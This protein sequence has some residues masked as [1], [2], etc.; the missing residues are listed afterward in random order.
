MTEGKAQINRRP[1]DWY[2]PGR[3]MVEF[4]NSPHQIRVLIGGR[5]SGKTTAVAVDAIF[6]HCYTYS[7]AR[8]YILR[9]TEKS[10]QDTTGETFGIVFGN[11][12]TVFLDTGLSLFKKI[13][14]GRQYR[15]PS[16]R[17]IELWNAWQ[18]AHPTATKQ[19]KL[20]WLE[21]V[22]DKY[23]SYLL[24]SGVPTSGHRQSRFRGFEASMIILVEADQFDREDVDLAMA[25][26]RWKG[27]EEEQCDEKGFLVD[28]RLILDTN[29]PSPRHWIARW[30]EE[31]KTYD[32]DGYIKFW[33][34]RTEENEHNLPPGYVRG[35]KRQ[36]QRNRAMYLRMLEGQYA[37]AFDGSPVLWAFREDHAHPDLD[38]PQGAYLVCG[39]DFGVTAHATIFSAYFEMGGC[40]YWWDLYEYYD[41]ERDTETQCRETLKIL[42][43]VFP[44]HNDRMFCAGLMHFCDVAGKQRK[45]SGRSSLQVLHSYGIYPSYQKFGVPESIATYNRLLEQKDGSGR[46]CYRIDSKNCP[47]LYAGSA[48]G[49]RYPAEGE[50]GHGG[51]LPGKGPQFGNYDHAVDAARYAKCNLLRLA[52]KGRDNRP[53]VGKLKRSLRVNRPRKWR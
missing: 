47:M 43:K 1:D 26:L 48:G 38:F 39:W 31:S 11:S 52:K 45:D 34:L 32:D 46:W 2:R 14:G 17:A 37:E 42:D 24:F 27:V 35:L 29:P 5:G 49:Y 40:E 18:Q 12:G 25:C 9:K 7:G 53:P 51:D 6:R 44:W 41:E 3:R 50:P 23:C 8:V 16:K 13:E 22:G 33:H 4:H 20:K 15:I 19:D 21:T 10:N 30:E 36:Y 28:Q